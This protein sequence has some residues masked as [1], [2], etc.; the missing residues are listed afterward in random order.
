MN[1]QFTLQTLS[2]I[3]DG[4]VESATDHVVADCL[5]RPGDPRPRKVVITIEFTP[6]PKPGST[7]ADQIDVCMV[8][9]EALPNRETCVYQMQPSVDRGKHG[10]VFSQGEE[11]PLFDNERGEQ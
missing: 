3:D 10:L 2:Q 1:T 4:A 11:T 8:V 5:E 7:E 9:K 6:H